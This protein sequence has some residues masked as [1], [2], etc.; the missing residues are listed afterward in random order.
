MGGAEKRAESF[1]RAVSLTLQPC[2]GILVAVFCKKALQVFTLVLGLDTQVTIEVRQ[3]VSPHYERV[4]LVPRKK[5][6]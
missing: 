4:E 6:E 1:H 2:C 5:D 3:S